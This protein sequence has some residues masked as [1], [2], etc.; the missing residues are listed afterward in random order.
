MK[1]AE[2]GGF[3]QQGQCWVHAVIKNVNKVYSGSS[4]MS[5]SMVN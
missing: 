1:G 5:C 3:H 2:L 4:P